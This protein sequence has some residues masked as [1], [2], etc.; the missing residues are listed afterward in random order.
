MPYL[1]PAAAEADPAAH[2]SPADA[3]ARKEAAG[4]LLR[5]LEKLPPRQQEVIQLKF[6]NG[7]SYQE[8]SEVTQLSVSHV[9]VLIHKGI[10][11]LREQHAALA[12]Q[13]VGVSVARPVVPTPFPKTAL[14]S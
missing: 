1:D 13:Y 10:R 3:L 12:G 14:P 11:A 6:Q 5:I 4:F 8:I 2:P 9:G 7:L